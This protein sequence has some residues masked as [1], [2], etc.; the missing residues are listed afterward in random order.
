MNRGTLILI[1]AVVTSALALGAMGQAIRFQP[2]E[3]NPAAAATIRQI[4]QRLPT[5]DSASAASILEQ[6]L[7][8]LPDGLASL[9]KDGLISVVAWI[10]LLPPA[11]KQALA[12]D[13]VTLAE[14]AARTALETLRREPQPKPESFAA[15]ARRYPFTGAAI[16]AAIEGGD[17]ALQLG[18]APTAWACYCLAKAR[19]WTPDE[20]HAATL[21]A[22]QY[23]SGEDVAELSGPAAKR[24]ADLAACAKTY[25]GPVPFDAKWYGRPEAV[26]MGRHLPQ[27]AAGVTYLASPGYVL[28]IKDTGQVLWRWTSPD[29]W[30]RTFLPDRGFGRGRGL[31]F[32]P[33]L[34]IGAGGAQILVCR[35]PRNGS[36]DF[37]IRAWRGADGKLLWSTQANAALD[38]F[39]FISTPAVC[40]K[41]VYATAVEHGPDPPNLIL[42]ALDLL[43][44]AVL[45]QAPLGTLG[46]LL[47]SHQQMRGWDDFQ[48]QTEP[49]VWRDLVIV[50]PNIGAAFAVGRFDGKVRWMHTYTPPQP[51]TVPPRI[52][53]AP[54]DPNQLLRWRNT[55]QVCG[56]AIVI[57]PQDVPSM[58]ALD[59]RSGKSLWTTA[60]PAPTLIG[61]AGNLA[62]FAGS[63]IVAVDSSTGA[64]RWTY[65]PRPQRITGPAAVV[66]G[67]VFV[68][69]SDSRLYI[70]N[71]QTGQKADNSIKPLGF[72]QAIA[73]ETVRRALDDTSIL[74]TLGPPAAGR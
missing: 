9:D 63:E 6:A 48:E 8:D 4:E 71:A 54:S 56:N 64:T 23:L 21:A 47:R 32:A 39:H 37:C 31:S 45:F 15:L 12:A 19:G 24:V 46:G 13:Y 5:G 11:Q 10:D 18:D 34:F 73:S 49:A 38:N 62:I 43:D 41:Y 61:R 59:L 40:G 67:I 7:R 52:A 50:T 55:P 27:A 68:P 53:P 22:C 30:A 25:R 57:A 3:A 65:A 14:P 72:R 42:V 58:F 16:S 60:A 1:Q 20:Q 66:G 35:Q 26:E 2:P 28:A 29:A 44:G 33:A 51:D 36:P 70:L 74:R 17:R 69:L